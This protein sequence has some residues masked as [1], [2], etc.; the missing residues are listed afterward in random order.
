[1]S[2]T[3]H[4]PQLYPN[5]QPDDSSDGDSRKCF[6]PPFKR[7][8][9]ELPPDE[10]EEEDEAVVKRKDDEDYK[11]AFSTTLNLQ[12]KRSDSTLVQDDHRRRR[13]AVEHQFEILKLIQ[14]DSNKKKTLQPIAPAKSRI[15]SNGCSSLATE[16]YHRPPTTTNDV[17]VS[18]TVGL[19]PCISQKQQLSQGDQKASR[20]VG[21]QQKE[22]GVRRSHV[23]DMSLAPSRTT[24]SSANPAAP[25]AV[26]R[27]QFQLSP[28]QV[29]SW[30]SSKPSPSSSEQADCM[31]GE[32][33]ACTR[34][35]AMLEQQKTSRKTKTSST[36]RRI[37][38]A[39]DI[40]VTHQPGRTNAM[41]RITRL[42]DGR[43]V[44]V[45]GTRHVVKAISEGS[46]ILFRCPHC[47]SLLQVSKF[48]QNIYCTLCRQVSPAAVT[49]A[50]SA[51]DA[52]NCQVEAST[53]T[54]T[55]TTTHPSP[56]HLSSS[57][58]A[59]SSLFT[60]S[61]SVTRL[62]SSYNDFDDDWIAQTVQR[63]EMEVATM[64]YSTK[65]T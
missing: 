20:Q 47:R 27:P 28:P 59:S 49:T 50:P 54:S 51:P 33:Q 46:A 18:P 37:S 3:Q 45:R 15:S 42:S 57:S 36:T 34:D 48:S 61:S 55:T 32:H 25:V 4:R 26:H 2:K 13:G 52:A 43:K 35:R 30:S 12:E 5:F 29:S 19:A 24:Y 39:S 14:E 38:R 62:A 10:E 40:A 63:Q 17:D 21:T 44:R 7:L 64:R 16:R 31:A 8:Y 65:M 58:S 60:S 6:Q 11:M 23:Q 9:P 1:M 41:D 53:S 22:E 56:L